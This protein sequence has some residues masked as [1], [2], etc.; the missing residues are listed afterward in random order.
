MN[1]AAITAIATPLFL[2]FAGQACGEDILK[3][4]KSEFLGFKLTDKDFKLCSGKSIPIR[5]TDIVT[6]A[7]AGVQCDEPGR[8]KPITGIAVVESVGANNKIKV[9]STEAPAT[10]Y[11]LD[12]STKKEHVKWLEDVGSNALKPGTKLKFQMLDGYLY[13]VDIDRKGA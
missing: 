4:E 9:K 10:S 7:P 2:I 8:P 1:I 3:R 11:E 13:K 12:L 5:S 6:N